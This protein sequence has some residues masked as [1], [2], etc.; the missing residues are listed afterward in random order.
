MHAICTP[1]LIANIIVVHGCIHAHTGTDSSIIYMTANGVCVHTSTAEVIH[2]RRHNLKQIR[3]KYRENLTID[4]GSCAPD[5][6]GC[7]APLERNVS[8]MTG[9]RRALNR[10]YLAL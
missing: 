4:P 9:P 6:K 8:G 5:P 10:R 1:L 7:F 2:E 3:R